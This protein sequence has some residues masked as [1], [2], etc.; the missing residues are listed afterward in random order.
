MASAD[1]PTGQQRL[2]ACFRV[3]HRLLHVLGI[4]L[5]LGGVLAVAAAGSLHDRAVVLG[6]V[7]AVSGIVLA[8]WFVVL[9]FD[10]TLMAQLET[11]NRERRGRSD[12]AAAIA[13]A[14][15]ER[16]ALLERIGGKLDSVDQVA[17]YVAVPGAA[18]LLDELRADLSGLRH[19]AA[20]L[21][22]ALAA[23]SAARTRADAD[24][25][26][27]ETE[28]TR[29]ASELDEMTGSLRD[30]LG[31]AKAAAE[32]ELAR[33]HAAIELEARMT[34]ALTAFD[35]DL[36]VAQRTLAGDAV[37]YSDVERL[38]ER[39]AAVCES[40]NAFQPAA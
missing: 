25:A 33:C 23:M 3:R 34:A 36:A 32:A 5:A 38:H 28:V 12:L 15:T 18:A 39:L 20:A 9:G 14:P 16:K 27:L 17:T 29:I 40:C 37:S 35:S 21:A 31:A 10:R 24:V 6:A 19:R 30:A 1:V 4:P 2:A 7:A 8:V 26:R 13:A 11:E 22:T